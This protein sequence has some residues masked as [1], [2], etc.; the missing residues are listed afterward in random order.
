MI[1][2][3]NSAAA[4]FRLKIV[5]NGITLGTAYHF[6]LPVISDGSKVKSRIVCDLMHLEGAECVAT[7][8][9]NFYA[10]TPAVTKNRFGSGITYYIGT[11]MDEAGIAKVL[12]MASADAEVKSVISEAT[13]LE[14]TC[15]KA[16]DCKFYFVMNFKEEEIEIPSCLA[17]NTDILTGKNVEAGEKLKK[18]DVRIIRGDK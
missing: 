16:D 2:D 7:Y 18:F 10:G 14:V 1:F 13:E 3:F 12:E 5:I 11:D 9:S 17:G 4:L 15:R 8:E 6:L